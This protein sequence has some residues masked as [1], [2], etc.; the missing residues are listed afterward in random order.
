M[1]EVLVNELF[2]MGVWEQ[3][4]RSSSL[5]STWIGGHCTF[6][7][8]YVCEPCHC[9]WDLWSKHLIWKLLQGWLCSFE[10]IPTTAVVT[11]V[12]K[13]ITS[14]TSYQAWEPLWPTTWEKLLPVEHRKG[15]DIS[16]FWWWL[17][18]WV[19]LSKDWMSHRIFK[20]LCSLQFLDFY[21][22]LPL[23]AISLK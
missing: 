5:C 15:T 6:L 14:T 21:S 2:P 4:L 19:V 18:S 17:V 16:C 11:R 9:Y 22:P 12:K 8:G 23:D 3:K 20:F 10:W 13:T 7:S 1:M